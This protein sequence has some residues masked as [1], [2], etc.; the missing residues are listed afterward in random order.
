[1]DLKDI[2]EASSGRIFVFTVGLLGSG[3]ALEY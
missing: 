2:A 3:S 1:M